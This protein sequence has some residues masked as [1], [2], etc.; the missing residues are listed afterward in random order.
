M[1]Y[2]P[3]TDWK[4][5]EIVRASDMNRI[6][7]AVSDVYDGSAQSTLVELSAV[8]E[9]DEFQVRRNNTS[10][11]TKIS[12]ILAKILVDSDLSS[13]STNP[14]QNKAIN[15][16]LANKVDKVEG[17]GLST[18]DYTTAEKAKVTNLPDNTNTALSNKVDKESGKAL[19]TN[20]YTNAEKT[21]VANCPDDTN[22]E[23]AKFTKEWIVTV[24]LSGWS[25]S[26]TNGWYT[27][28]I[29]VSEMKSTYNPKA[30]VVYSSSSTVEQDDSAMSCIKEIL[31]YDGYVICRA[32]EK[33]ETDVTVRLS[34]V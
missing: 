21:K 23:L 22:A 14:V 7:Q 3:K 2:T 28:Q 34:G 13:T 18:N 16:A 33:P 29:T 4:D 27:N 6:E 31:T 30:D 12:A 20:D 9:T 1:A 19:S 25:S 17:K 26:T 10:Y 11:R 5:N 15:A 24:P 8:N 32:I